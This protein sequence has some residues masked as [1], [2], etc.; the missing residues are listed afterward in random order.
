ML[1]SLKKAPGRGPQDVWLFGSEYGF[2]G[3]ASYLRLS[4]NEMARHHHKIENR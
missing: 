4:E 1:V 3:A 2:T